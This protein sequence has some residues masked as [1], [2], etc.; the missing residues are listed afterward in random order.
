M[1]RVTGRAGA[2]ATAPPV[3]APGPTPADG[4]ARGGTTLE[5]PSRKA[6]LV[7]PSAPPPTAGVRREARIDPL[8]LAA[9]AR[10]ATK[11]PSR[12]I[13]DLRADAL[14][15]G[16]ELVAPLLDSLGFAAALLSP[17]DLPAY[18]RLGLRMPG[19]QAGS[20]ASREL[21][22]VPAEEL[23]GIARRGQRPV[24]RL[25]AEVVGLKRVRAGEGVSYGASYRTERETD[26]ALVGMGYSD[27]AVRRASGRVRV[28][29]GSRRGLIAGAISMDQ[30]S[31]DLGGFAE[32][33]DPPVR[34]GDEAVLWGDPEAGEPHLL[35][36]QEACGV[37]AAAVVSRLSARVARTL[38]EPPVDRD[39]F[40]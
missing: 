19:A 37:P 10:A 13:A 11:H 2:D 9:N 25:S 15:H 17:A 24:M 34:L 14:G 32:D 29:V 30:F 7:A 36:W 28:R 40:A 39:P 31:V 4:R 23:L 18:E 26:L 16:L 35:D 21:A 8:A 3:Q 38:A 1:R 33:A 20:E 5:A 27:G 6:G 22:H 12:S